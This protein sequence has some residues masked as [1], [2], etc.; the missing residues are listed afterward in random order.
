M[1]TRLEPKIT[2]YSKWW[3]WLVL[4]HGV[5]SCLIRL[6]IYIW[7]PG[8]FLSCKHPPSHVHWGWPRFSHMS[9]L[10]GRNC[11]RL[12]TRCPL[13][14]LHPSRFL[15]ELPDHF[16]LKP[17]CSRSWWGRSGRTSA[18]RF[19][20]NHSQ[21][22]PQT[23]SSGGCWIPS[24]RKYLWNEG[25]LTPKKPFIISFFILC[26]NLIRKHFKKAISRAL[27]KALWTRGTSR[28]CQNRLHLRL[29]DGSVTW[30]FHLMRGSRASCMLPGIRGSNPKFRRC[31]S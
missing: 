20:Q 18:G 1:P 9:F 15:P 26:S 2:V 28:I 21:S 29:A 3:I 31:T 24:T 17:W 13:A 5:G 27:S 19:G 4:M 30:V 22:K 12:L 7:T 23:E 25:F 11:F 8:G 10:A 14:E 16:Q 6:I